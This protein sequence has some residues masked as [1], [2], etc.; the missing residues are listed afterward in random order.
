[1]LDE[2]GESMRAPALT[3]PGEA[4]VIELEAGKFPVDQAIG[5]IISFEEAPSALREWAED[6]QPLRQDHGANELR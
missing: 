4:Q 5:R 6:P 3:G 1:M 2:T